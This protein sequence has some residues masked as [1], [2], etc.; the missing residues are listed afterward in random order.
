[1]VEV[2]LTGLRFPGWARAAIFEFGLA[3][4]GL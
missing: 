3:I 4:L 2:I 1:M